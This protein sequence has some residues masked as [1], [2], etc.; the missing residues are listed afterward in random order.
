MIKKLSKY[1]RVVDTNRTRRLVLRASGAVPLLGLL[2]SS[3][4]L[5]APPDPMLP[6]ISVTGGPITDMYYPGS[7]TL[8]TGPLPPSRIPSVLAN[9]NISGP[10]LRVGELYLVNG[11]KILE[12]IERGDS[13]GTL[14]EFA[15]GLEHATESAVRAQAA[16]YGLVTQWLATGGYI[17][18]PGANQYAFTRVGSMSTLFGVFST[19]YFRNLPSRPASEFAFY[20]SPFMSI[21]AIYYWMFGDGSPRTMNIQSLNLAMSL[22][23]FAQINRAVENPAYS[24]GTYFFDSEFS[25]NLFDHHT[26]DLWAA[27]VIGRVSGRVTGTLEMSDKGDYVFAGSFTLNPDRYKAYDSNRTL[28]QEVLTKFLGLLGTFG[29]KDYDIIF[30]GSQNITFSGKRPS[31]NQMPVNPGEAVHRPSFGGRPRPSGT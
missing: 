18:Q 21:A 5:A 30:T 31:A 2:S 9:G 14:V 28:T 27:G 10:V 7:G 6:V 13:N 1:E 11:K 4:S 3:K 17:N 19:W 8:G 22:S 29:H 20:G 15:T 25:T 12:A 26:K 16:V 24:H 23:D